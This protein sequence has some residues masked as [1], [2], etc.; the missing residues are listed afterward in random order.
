MGHSN[1]QLMLKSKLS[2]TIHTFAKQCSVH[3]SAI[4]ADARDDQSIRVLHVY[5]PS[6]HLPSVICQVDG[7]N[8]A[9]QLSAIVAKALRLPLKS[10]SFA[11]PVDELVLRSLDSP[12]SHRRLCR[13]LCRSIPPTSSNSLRSHGTRLLQQMLFSRPRSM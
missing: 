8:V 6:Q 11:Y 4:S 1:K 5:A 12:S 2:C 7:L 10:P 3:M 13:R 9:E